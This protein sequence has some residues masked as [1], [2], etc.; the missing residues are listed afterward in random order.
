MTTLY[1]SPNIIIDAHEW[2]VLVTLHHKRVLLQYR[3]RPLSAK[4]FRWLPITSWQGPKPK[5]MCNRFQKFK[6]HV[7]LAME[8]E[9]LRQE[10]STRLRGVSGAMLRNEG[11]AA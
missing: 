7:L 8:S 1:R 5:N 9:R 6:P 10:A 2:H 3:W 4:Q 11:L